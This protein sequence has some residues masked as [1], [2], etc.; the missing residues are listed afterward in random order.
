MSE[1][2]LRG[3]EGKYRYCLLVDIS[4]TDINCYLILK[5]CSLLEVKETI[6]GDK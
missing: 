6:G 5:R 4:D 2:W 1:V 3:V